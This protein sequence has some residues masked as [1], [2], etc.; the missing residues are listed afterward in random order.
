MAEQP[1]KTMPYG[2]PCLKVAAFSPKRH[3]QRVPSETD[4]KIDVKIPKHKNCNRNSKELQ[5]I[6]NNYSLK[7]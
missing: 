7:A 1:N 6:L 4:I 2:T 5:Q 3:E